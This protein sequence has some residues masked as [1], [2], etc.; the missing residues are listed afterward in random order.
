MKD[1][2]K[3]HLH[4]TCAVI[5]R[6][7]LILSAQR[8]EAMSMPLKWEFPG[9]KIKEGESREECLK[10]EILEELGVHIAIL[11]PLQ[12]S[13]HD[14][15]DITVTLYPFLCRI[16]EGVLTLHEHSDLKWSLPEELQSLDWAEA[17]V[18]VVRDFL[19]DFLN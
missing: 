6:E 13:T 1:E 7:G 4:V 16:E 3:K 18:P 14:Y 12:P 2:S 9:G 15:P 19:N 10:R 5:K 8:S 17:D 11:S